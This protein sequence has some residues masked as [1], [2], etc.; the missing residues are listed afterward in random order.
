MDEERILGSGIR[1]WVR[2]RVQIKIKVGA[3][4]GHRLLSIFMSTMPGIRVLA[5]VQRRTPSFD[6]CTEIGSQ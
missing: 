3:G 1:I 4:L 6:H 2:V 5:R